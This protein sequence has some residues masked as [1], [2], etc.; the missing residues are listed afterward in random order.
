MRTTKIKRNW[1]RSTQ[2]NGILLL[3]LRVI[4]P[5]FCWQPPQK[6]NKENEKFGIWKRNPRVIKIEDKYCKKKRKNVKPF[7]RNS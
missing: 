2:N 6:I 5:T 4:V 7:S 3:E 1:C